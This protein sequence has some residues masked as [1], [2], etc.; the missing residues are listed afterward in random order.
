MGRKAVLLNIV[1]F[2]MFA[3][4]KLFP[5]NKKLSSKFF[6]FQTCL[7]KNFHLN[8]YFLSVIICFLTQKRNF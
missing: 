6:L 8:S 5:L 1:P 2:H 7:E 4:K 3:K